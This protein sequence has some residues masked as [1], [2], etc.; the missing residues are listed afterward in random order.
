MFDHFLP[1]QE[2][3]SWL[4][5]CCQ[6]HN[7]APGSAMVGGNHYITQGVDTDSCSLY[8]SVCCSI[9]K[10]EMDYITNFSLTNTNYCC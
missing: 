3:S 8:F 6:S 9:E 5:F 4:T 1:L 2:E 10:E 7:W